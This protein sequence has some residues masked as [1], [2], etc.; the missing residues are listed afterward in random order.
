MG[1]LRPTSILLGVFVD[2]GI[3]VAFAIVLAA[4]LGLSSPAFQIMALACGLVATLLGGF[5]AAW[6]ARGEYVLHGFGVGSMA[7]AISLSRFLVNI[8]WPP[9][10]A[11]AVHPIWWEL[12]G[13]T[14]ALFAG[15]TGGWFAHLAA[16][17][18]LVP[19]TPRPHE[20]RRGLWSIVLLA[21]I[22]L[23]AIAEHL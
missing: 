20:L 12:I 13:W 15:L 23:F 6:H 21:V 14:G 5:V 17:R 9:A 22:V 1:S 18:S 3:F 2:K 19:L 4:V 11:A 8:V 10:Q 7:V 16:R